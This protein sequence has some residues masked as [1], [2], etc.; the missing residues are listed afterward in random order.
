MENFL[1]PFDREF[2]QVL[3]AIN[4]QSALDIVL[5]GKSLTEGKTEHSPL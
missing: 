5:L 1:A 4:M 2:K 3:E